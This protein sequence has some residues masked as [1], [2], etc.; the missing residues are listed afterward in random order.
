MINQS[1]NIMS[2]FV[3]ITRVIQSFDW[4]SLGYRSG[5]LL[6]LAIITSRC[7]LLRMM[8]CLTTDAATCILIITAYLK[9]LKREEEQLNYGGNQWQQVRGSLLRLPLSFLL[10]FFC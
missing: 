10:L 9:Q 7:P 1:M 5:V 8:I 3:E 4:F 6:L 2:S